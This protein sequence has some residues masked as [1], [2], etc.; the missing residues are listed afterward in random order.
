M[1]AREEAVEQAEQDS[2]AGEVDE[3]ETGDGDDGGIDLPAVD[4]EEVS[5]AIEQLLERIRGLFG[6]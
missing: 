6:G 2:D 1:S 5:N 4:D 3:G